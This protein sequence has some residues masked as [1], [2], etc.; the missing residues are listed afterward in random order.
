MQTAD[1]LVVDCVNNAPDDHALRCSLR[2]NV[3]AT[4]HNLT[5]VE[6]ILQAETKGALT[7][8]GDLLVERS[9]LN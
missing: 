1:R 3:Y 5:I 8:N 9:C 7:K 6:S 4:D 2:A